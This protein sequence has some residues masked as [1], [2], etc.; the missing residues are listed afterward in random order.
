MIRTPILIC[1]IC[2]IV[3]SVCR[4]SSSRQHSNT[5]EPR[6]ILIKEFEGKDWVC[7]TGTDG[8]RSIADG[9]TKL[10]SCEFGSKV[11][12]DFRVE[13]H[14]LGLPD[15][16]RKARAYDGSL[17]QRIYLEKCS[18]RIGP[19]NMVSGN[20]GMEPTRS[21][22]NAWFEAVTAKATTAGC[23]KEFQAAH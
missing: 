2:A 19:A 16:A 18:I 12:G 4:D 9:W 6:A 23:G 3:V 13:I 20:Y 21:M 7:Q 10:Y 14:Q 17:V 11:Y 5:I 1:L 8:P 22:Y 15:S